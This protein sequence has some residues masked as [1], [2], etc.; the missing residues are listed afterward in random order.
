[1]MTH[2][3][4]RLLI[5]AYSTAMEAGGMLAALALRSS[6]LSRQ[7]NL[8]ERRGVPLPRGSGAAAQSV[9]LHAAS[10]G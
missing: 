6:H 10:L 1:M 9:W 3:P 4:L 8:G 2:L 5:L 7:W